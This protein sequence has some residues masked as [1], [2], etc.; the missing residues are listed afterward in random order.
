[1]AIV[2]MKKIYLFAHRAEKEK[3]VRALQSLGLV[4]IRQVEEKP[5]WKGCGDLRSIQEPE[6]LHRL[7]SRLNEIKYSLDLLAR[8]FPLKKGFLEQ[9]AGSKMTLTPEEFS[10]FGAEGEQV[11]KIYQACRRLDEGFTALGNEENRV[12][13]LLSDLAPYRD[14]NLPLKELGV[15]ERVSVRLGSL[16]AASLAQFKDLLAREAP[17]TH[18]QV[19]SQDKEVAHIFLIYLRDCPPVEAALKEHNWTDLQVPAHL[20]ASPAQCMAQLEEKL[21]REREKGQGLLAQ[22]E[23]LLPQRPRLMAYYDYLALKR[24]RLAVT[25]NFLSTDQAVLMTGWARAAD[26]PQIEE[27]LAQVGET[28]TLLA[29]DPVEGEIPPVALKNG[30]LVEPFEAVTNLYSTPSPKEIDPTAA[31]A[32]FFFVFFGITLGD[33][34]YGILLTLLSLLLLKLMQP[35]GMGEQLIK[36]LALGGGAALCFGILTGSWFGDMINLPPLWFNPLDDPMKMLIFS[37]ALGVIHLFAGMAIQAYRSIAAGKPWDAVFDQGFWY[38]LLIGLML[39]ALPAVAGL[40]K[41][42]AI[43]GAVGLVLTQGRGQK[44]MVMKFFSGLL[45]LY[46]LTGYLSDVL[47]YSRLLALGL[48]SGVIAVAINTMGRL[49]GSAGVVGFVLMLII[50]IGGHFFNLI[51]GTLGAYVHTSRL[52]YIE[53][54][55][56]FFEGGGKAFTPFKINT[57]YVD[58][59]EREA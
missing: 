50:L 19:V 28:A 10:T 4:E 37:M 29:R 52:Q 53:Y 43:A 5:T 15:S 27:H 34:G 33:A 9:F 2:E 35:K 23:K 49:V 38:L 18:V 30:P 25:D 14:L 54:F 22:V 46:D 7:E 3:M 26:I 40:G 11:D 44:N 6:A 48:A 57:Q 39:L 24:D 55:G 36:L 8:H 41:V 45:S 59:E 16:P 31:L 21:A 32:P 51:I 58:L 12:E 13:N 56:K 42:L 20:T 1:M 47:S 17:E